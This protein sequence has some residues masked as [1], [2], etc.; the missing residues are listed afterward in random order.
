MKYSSLLVLALSAFEL[1]ACHPYYR[2][3]GRG[4]DRHDRGHYEPP[5]RPYHDRRW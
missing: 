4:W 3:H 1:T 2:D 5:P